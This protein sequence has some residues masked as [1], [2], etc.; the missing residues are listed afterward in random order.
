MREQLRPSG[1]KQRLCPWPIRCPTDTVPA[2]L[3]FLLG[4]AM[5]ELQGG[6]FENLAVRLKGRD[7]PGS[8]VV[9]P[10]CSQCRGHGFG[11]FWENKMLHATLPTK[12][13]SIKKKKRLKGRDLHSHFHH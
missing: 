7:F 11:P 4:G 3:R 2:A 9:R 6:S 5:A 1:L 8:P 13:K 12:I 10:L